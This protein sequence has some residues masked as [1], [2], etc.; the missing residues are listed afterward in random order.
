MNWLRK[1]IVNWLRGSEVEALASLGRD[2]VAQCPDN[3]GDFNMTFLSA[4]NGKVIQIRTYA[5]HKNPGPD[6]K[7]EY[8]IVPDGEK[9]TDALTLLMIAKNLE[10]A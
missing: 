10:K 1:R 8:F 5:P 6:W 3:P 4:M 7:T 9:L 2:V